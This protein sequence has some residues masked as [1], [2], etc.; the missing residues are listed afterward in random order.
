MVLQRMV[1]SGLHLIPGASDSGCVADGSFTQALQVI[2]IQTKVSELLTE[3]VSCLM[4][5]GVILYLLTRKAL[6]S[7]YKKKQNLEGN[8]Q[9]S[10]CDS[11]GS[12]WATNY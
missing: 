8:Y 6:R 5:P 1:D 12:L 10:I 3:R 2:P 7:T 4:I 11:L 9:A